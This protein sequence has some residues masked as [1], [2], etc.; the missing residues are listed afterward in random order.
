MTL[1]F[2][3]N[4][5]RHFFPLTIPYFVLKATFFT[6]AS[7]EQVFGEVAQVVRAS[8]SYPPRRTRV[9]RE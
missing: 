3:F 9:Q 7:L 8:D 4:D 1:V 6:F 2:F 5:F